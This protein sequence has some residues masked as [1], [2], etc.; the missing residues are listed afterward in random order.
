MG[1][2][3]CGKN[4]QHAHVNES[5]PVEGMGKSGRERKTRM[6]Y[7]ARTI[8]IKYCMLG[9]FPPISPHILNRLAKVV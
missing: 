6:L 1:E 9:V 7:L 3:G 2:C 4:E 5:H 8:S